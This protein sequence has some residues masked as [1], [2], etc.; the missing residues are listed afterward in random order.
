MDICGP[1]GDW[2]NGKRH[3]GQ[4]IYGQNSGDEYP[5]TLSWGRS[6][7]GQLKNQSSIMQEDN[8]IL[9]R[10]RI[11]VI[12][13]SRSWN[14]NFKNTKVESYS[15]VTLWKMIQDQH[16]LNRYHQHYRWQPQKSWTWFQDYWDA[17]DK[18]EMEYL[19][20][21]RSKWKIQW[22]KYF[23]PHQTKPTKPKM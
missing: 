18:P 8:L 22:L 13:R 14:H 19:L 7:N 9:R 20:I 17:Q 2:Q 11:S 5:R 23:I 4:I 1:G 21:R 16:S 10:W 6:I 3:P 15:E 12:L